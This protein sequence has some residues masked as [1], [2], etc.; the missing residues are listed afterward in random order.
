MRQELRIAGGWVRDKLLRMSSHDLDVATSAMSGYEFATRFVPWIDAQR[1]RT[2]PTESADR[3]KPTTVACIAANPDQSK[4]LETATARV[5]DFDLDFVQLRSE[6]YANE[7]R[8]PS[9]VRR[10]GW[11]CRADRAGHRHARRG[12][13]ETRS[14]DQRAVL[15]RAH[16]ARRGLDR[17]GEGRDS[18]VLWLLI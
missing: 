7:S 9:V 2:G 5:Y 1:A 4:H 16:Q 15:Q 10:H 18:A 13:A 8:I 17:Q 14:D 11:P 3:R 6:S 12:R